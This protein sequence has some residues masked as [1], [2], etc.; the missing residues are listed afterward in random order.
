MSNVR[1]P[2]RPPVPAMLRGTIDCYHFIALS[3]TFTVPPG[4]TGSEQSKIS[5]L[6]ILA[7]FLTDQD[8]I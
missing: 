8:Q 6:H 4:V 3:L 5:W 1:P 2:T 7:H